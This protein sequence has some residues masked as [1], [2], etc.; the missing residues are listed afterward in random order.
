MGWVVNATIR[1]LYPPGKR[2]CAPCTGGW[3]G[4]GVVLDEMGK[5][6]RNRVSNRG[7]SSP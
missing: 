6:R 2:R 5:S 7:P 3:V 4:L 1:P